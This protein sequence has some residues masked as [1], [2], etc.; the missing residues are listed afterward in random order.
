LIAEGRL[1]TLKIGGVRVI[2]GTSMRALVDPESA[3]Q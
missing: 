2:T 3:A 1:K